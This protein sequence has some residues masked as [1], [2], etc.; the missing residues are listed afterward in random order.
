MSFDYLIEFD[1]KRISYQRLLKL[2]EMEDDIIMGR[3]LKDGGAPQVAKLC[4]I[5]G[6]QFTGVK[7]Y[8]NGNQIF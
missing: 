5:L 2:L 3:P 6:H 7:A 1:G 4:Q 8:F